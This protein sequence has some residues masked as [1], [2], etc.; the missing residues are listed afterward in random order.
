M[1]IKVNHL[2][3]LSETDQNQLQ[4]T[5]LGFELDILKIMESG[6][7]DFIYFG[8][9][10]EG[11]YVKGKG[12]IDFLVLT[13][14]TQVIQYFDA[15]SDLHRTYRRQEG[16]K[17]YL[18]GSYLQIDTTNQITGG[19]YIGTNETG[20]K[21]FV[22]SIFTVVD[23]AHILN[24]A[25]GRHDKF[26]LKAIFEY[27]SEAYR[28]ALLEM[29][30]HHLKISQRF[31]DWDFRLHLIHTGARSF[32]QLKDNIN[33]PKMKALEWLSHQESFAAFSPLLQN[34]KPYRSKLSI[35]EKSALDCMELDQ[36]EQLIAKLYQAI[37]ALPEKQQNE[38]VCHESQ[39]EKSTT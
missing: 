31:N 23:H 32:A 28:V 36:I 17:K 18:E 2:T 13:R 7:L 6:E 39:P 30:N 21:T 16:F 19:I 33:L 35:D 10:S 38:E 15:I 37:L 8:S 20:W 22:N 11:T 25:M 9:L 29:A 26:D 24:T 27:E 3:Y 14:D 5:L 1:P 12:D 4:D 34:L